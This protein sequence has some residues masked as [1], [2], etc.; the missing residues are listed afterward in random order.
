MTT[1]GL[2]ISLKL[3]LLTTLVIIY[4]RHMFILQAT[5]SQQR[6]DESLMRLEPERQIDWG[7]SGPPS[8]GRRVPAIHRGSPTGRWRR[9]CRPQ[10]SAPG[11]GKNNSVCST[12]FFLQSWNLKVPR[13]LV[14]NHL[15]YW[16]FCQCNPVIWSA[17]HWRTRHYYVLCLSAKC[18]RPKDLTK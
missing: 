17:G 11:S 6:R 9:W 7:P 10:R 18:F 12:T 2:S 15:P 3:H 8:E 13:L 14:K 5:E 4:D 1:L 16:P